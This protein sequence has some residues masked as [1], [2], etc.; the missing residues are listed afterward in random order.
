[1]CFLKQPRM[2]F[3]FLQWA[4]GKPVIKTNKS[5]R[6]GFPD[7]SVVKN[8][9]ANAQ[10]ADL[11][12]GLGR[13][14][15]EGKG[16][17]LHYSCLENSMDRGTLRASM[18]SQRV[19]HYLVTTAITELQMICLHLAFPI[20]R[21]SPTTV[22]LPWGESPEETRLPTCILDPGSQQI[23]LLPSCLLSVQMH[24]IPKS[25]PASP[26]SQP[27]LPPAC[28]PLQHASTSSF[29]NSLSPHPLHILTLPPTIQLLPQL[30]Q[31]V[32]TLLAKLRGCQ[33]VLRV[34]ASLPCGL[35][36]HTSPGPWTLLSSSSPTSGTTLPSP[37]LTSLLVSLRIPMIS[38]ALSSVM[39]SHWK[40]V[41]EPW[42]T[43]GFL[44]SREEEFNLGPV[45]CSELLCN[46]VLLKYRRD[47][48][49]FQHRYQKGAE[50]V[51][52]C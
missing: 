22:T 15:G 21:T 37:V 43:P 41:T 40:V 6:W 18:G 44:A 9:P 19:R 35:C 45:D 31:A 1:M 38:R 12:P 46:K 5:S 25:H 14:P 26:S 8:L 36:C 13:S 11:I 49:S 33:V 50:R 16:Y 30:L 4:A 28:L 48:E 34:L 10:D 39:S 24:T 32:S 51:P 29:P 7:G 42:K 47:R 20:T 23:S 3:Y 2:G 17:P 27:L 52:P